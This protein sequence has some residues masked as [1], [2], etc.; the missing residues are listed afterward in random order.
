[1]KY[2]HIYI[3]PAVSA[4]R[5]EMVSTRKKPPASRSITAM[6]ATCGHCQG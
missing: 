4:T 6:Y 3:L 5:E 2:K 1:M